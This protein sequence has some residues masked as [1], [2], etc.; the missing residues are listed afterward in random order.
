[1]TDLLPLAKSSRHH[2]L[3]NLLQQHPNRKH[4]ACPMLDILKHADDSQSS[5]YGLKLLPCTCRLRSSDTGQ[6]PQGCSCGA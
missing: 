5:H 3:Q 2:T 4:S 6:L 1:M